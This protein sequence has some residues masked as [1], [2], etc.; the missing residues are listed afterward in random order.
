MNKRMDTSLETLK[1]Q[2]PLVW[3]RDNGHVDNFLPTALS[4]NSFS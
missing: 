3:Q 4:E 1:S 2:D